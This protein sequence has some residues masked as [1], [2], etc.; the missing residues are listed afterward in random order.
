MKMADIQNKA[1]SLGI[2]PSKMK[3]A[4]LIR[5]IQSQEGNFSC[6]QTSANGQ[7]SQESCCWRDDCLVD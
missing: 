5:S 2:K 7:C 3:K 6:F 1:K 4:D